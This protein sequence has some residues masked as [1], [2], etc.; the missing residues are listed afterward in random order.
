MYPDLGRGLK[1][2]FTELSLLYIS[3][4]GSLAAVICVVVVNSVSTAVP[5]VIS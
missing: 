1:V 5:F 3:S 4:V 2:K